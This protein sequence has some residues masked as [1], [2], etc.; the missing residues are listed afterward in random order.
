MSAPLCLTV[1]CLS[2]PPSASLAVTKLDILDT[3]PEVKVGAHYLLDG[4]RLDHFPAST[5]ELARVEVEYI[6][7]P[8]WQ[9][10]TENVRAFGDLPAN[11]QEYIRTLE[12]LVKVPGGWQTEGTGDGRQGGRSSAAADGWGGPVLMGL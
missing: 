6:T 11:A 5:A 10:S 9:Q 4:V 12:R 2:P 7:V 8:G 1:V 3:L